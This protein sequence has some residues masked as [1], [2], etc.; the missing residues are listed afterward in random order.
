MTKLLS[1]IGCSAFLLI[2]GSVGRADTLVLSG[3]SPAE[4]VHINAPTLNP[5]VNNVNA[6]SG[7]L[8]WLDKSVNPNK[9]LQSFCIDINHDISLGGTYTYN[10]GAQ[11]NT[12]NNGGD[13]ILTPTIVKEIYAL[14]N[15]Y[16]TSNLTTF[17][18][19]DA[20]SFQIALWDILYDGGSS[21]GAGPV[22]L[23]STDSTIESHIQTGFQW[24][25][26]AVANP[27]TT[28]SNFLDT[29]IFTSS[30]GQEQ[31]YIGPPVGA[32]VTPLPSALGGSVVLLGMI[33][34][35]KWRRA[36]C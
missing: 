24:A 28:N 1:A 20:N 14:W 17:S 25:A 9:S 7:V 6:Y 18:N 30:S 16:G 26:W 2:A 8:N 36:V 29:M 13:T 11:V 22:A 19:A 3:A 12:S 33:G 4:I 32:P 34:A 23:S 31:I 10:L 15:Q 27:D 5:A 35:F 21:T